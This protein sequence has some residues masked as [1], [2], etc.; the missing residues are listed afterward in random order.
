VDVKLGQSQPD[1]DP[2]SL[3]QFPNLGIGTTGA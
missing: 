3:T 1:P 2:G